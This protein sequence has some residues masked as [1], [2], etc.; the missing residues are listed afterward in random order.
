MHIYKAIL[1]YG[2]SNFSLDILEYCDPK[3][4][5]KKEYYIDFLKPEYN[6]LKIAGS[7]LG[8]KHSLNTRALMNINNTGIN[9][10]F[11][12]K[13]HTYESRIMTGESLKSIIKVNNKPKVVTL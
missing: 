9:Q 6:I 5:I 10:P 7:S 8:F 2:H 12:G 4:L 1:K 3:F 13:R 11:Y